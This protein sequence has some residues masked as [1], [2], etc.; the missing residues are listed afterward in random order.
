M[1]LVHDTLRLYREDAL[2]K[3][4]VEMLPVFAQVKDQLHLSDGQGDSLIHIAA[5][6]NNVSLLHYLFEME[7]NVQKFDIAQCNM[8]GDTPLHIAVRKDH[9]EIVR[10]LVSY[11]SESV[12]RCMDQENSDGFTP[13]YL[14]IRLER[15]EIYNMLKMPSLNEF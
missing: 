3:T 4:L 15:T 11:D 14:V 8:S 10:L 2:Q 9:K 7:G 1:P 6:T 12:Q 13:W 5:L